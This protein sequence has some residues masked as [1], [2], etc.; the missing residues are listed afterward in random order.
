MVQ[1]DCHQW[2]N[3]ETRKVC[4][5]RGWFFHSRYNLILIRQTKFFQKYSARNFD[6]RTSDYRTLRLHEFG[7]HDCIE[8]SWDDFVTGRCRW[9]WSS[10]AGSICL[11]HSTGCFVGHIRMCLKHSVWCDAFMFCGRTRRTFSR[12]DVVH[13]PWENDSRTSGCLSSKRNAIRDS[14]EWKSTIWLF[15]FQFVISFIFTIIGDIG[16]LIEFASF[17]IWVF[18][19]SAF[20]CLLVLRR[21]QPDLPRPY[22]VPTFIPYLCLAVA[23]FLSVTPMITEPPAKYL[24][25][26]SFIASGILFYI[27]FVYHQIRPRFMGKSTIASQRIPQL[28]LSLFINLQINLRFTYKCCSKWCRAIRKKR[29]DERRSRPR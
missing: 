6:C 28:Q 25:A 16:A 5:N 13:S 3:Q 27:P 8:S 14:K 22:R 10:R 21:T 2:G 15:Q 24:A 4:R 7:L 12:A 11:P 9:I 26:L 19:G 18:Y 17:L 1:C 29:D 23:I 20:V